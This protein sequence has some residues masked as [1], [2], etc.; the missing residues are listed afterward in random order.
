M[1]IATVF[2]RA[3]RW[4]DNRRAFQ[5]A[6]AD[7]QGTAT[8]VGLVL[9]QADDL[10]EGWPQVLRAEV[11]PNGGSRV[12]ASLDVGLSESGL[13]L[14]QTSPGEARVFSRFHPRDRAFYLR[15]FCGLIEAGL[16]H[17]A[18]ASPERRTWAGRGP[19]P[20]GDSSPPFVGGP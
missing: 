18:H 3:A 2:E 4:R 9:S 17:G 16:Q 7:L 15:R 8:A 10:I 19:R 14:M 5:A 13:M 12:L 20:L 11:R 6:L 1:T